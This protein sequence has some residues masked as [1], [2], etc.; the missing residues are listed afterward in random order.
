MGLKKH[1]TLPNGVQLNYHRVVSVLVITNQENVIEVA[2]YTSQA[3]RREEQ[4]AL[5]TAKETGEYPLTDVYIETQNVTCP[6]DQSMT[7]D[8]AYAWLKANAGY[9][10]ADDVLEEE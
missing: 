9:E 6:Y 3:K 2:S 4:A 10:D 7:V 5:A 8:S 1:V